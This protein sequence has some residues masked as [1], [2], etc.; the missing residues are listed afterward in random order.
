MKSNYQDL[1]KA[2]QVAFVAHDQQKRLDGRDYIYHP[3]S[4]MMHL[5]YDDYDT[6]IVALFHDL[7]EDE[8]YSITEIADTFGVE[9]SQA[10][11][12]LTRDPGQTYEQYIKSIKTS[13]NRMAIKVKRADLIHNLCTIDKIPDQQKRIRLKKRYET[14]L[15]E[16]S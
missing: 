12:I 9:I 6:Q 16:L 4:V 1:A 3:L 5:E 10:V 8:L 14:A 2:M 15:R 13:D 7:I 11:L